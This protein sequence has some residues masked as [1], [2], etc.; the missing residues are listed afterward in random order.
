MV[1]EYEIDLTCFTDC[2][3]E[4]GWRKRRAH[5]RDH[6]AYLYFLLPQLRAAT[7]LTVWSEGRSG[8][9]HRIAWN[10]LGCCCS[11]DVHDDLDARPGAGGQCRWSGTEGENLWPLSADFSAYEVE[12]QASFQYE[13]QA[14]GATRE[15]VRTIRKRPWKEP[16][17]LE[18]ENGAITSRFCKLLQLHAYLGRDSFK[19]SPA[20]GHA[21][22]MNCGESW[23]S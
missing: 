12:L 23:L 18:E 22:W 17:S 19:V 3:D 16:G 4:N 11:S 5:Q 6:R 14:P 1:S 15:F 21:A 2:S 20:L 7:L 13:L 10:M 9:S 8:R